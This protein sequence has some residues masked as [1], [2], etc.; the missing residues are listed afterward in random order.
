[1]SIFSKDEIQYTEDSGAEEKLKNYTPKGYELHSEH[2]L[3][4]PSCSKKLASIII[5]K[6]DCPCFISK[7][8]AQVNQMTVRAKCMKCKM[9]SFQISLERCKFYYSA[10]APLNLYNVDLD[11]D[12]NLLILEVV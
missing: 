10:H 2:I 7:D 4:C 11:L 6:K 5:V 3:T 9:L 8:G 12:K 1:M